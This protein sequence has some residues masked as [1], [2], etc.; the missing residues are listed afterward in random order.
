[1]ANLV[2]KD[3]SKGDRAEE[4]VPEA[5]KRAQAPLLYPLGYVMCAGQA[6]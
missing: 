1:M 2:F 5:R 3:G 4:T 6:G